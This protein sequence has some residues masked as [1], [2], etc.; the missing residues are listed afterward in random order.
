MKTL[1]YVLMLMV[2]FAANAQKVK[3]KDNLYTVDGVPYMYSTFKYQKNEVANF[4]SPNQKVV[5]FKA[6][7]FIDVRNINGYNS[8]T[9]Y[10]KLVF[11]NEHEFLFSTHSTLHIVKEIYKCECLT[12]EGTVDVKKL[13]ERSKAFRQS[14]PE[15]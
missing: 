11:N 8:I 6:I 9:R 1:L 3:L 10:S 4:T 2:S 5:Y 12:K 13:Q 14:P 7:T 15:Y